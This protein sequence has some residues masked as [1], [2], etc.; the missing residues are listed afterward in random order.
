M[1]YSESS[2]VLFTDLYQLTM[3]QAYWQAR[4]TAQGTFSLFF[5]SYP[6]NRGYFVFAGL[7][8]AI[9]YLEDLRFSPAD[10]DSLRSLD[11]FD[12]GYLEFL[13]GVRFTGNIRAMSEGSIVFS[14][15]PVMEVS[16]PII[17]AQLAE[18]YLV[19]IVNLQTILATKAS[20][21]IHAARG[22]TVVDFAARRT[23]GGE[24][25]LKLA[26]TSYMVGFAGTSNVMASTMF[27]I[28]AYGTM[29]HSFI[30]TF[31]EETDAF[32]AYAK[33]FPDTSTFLVDTFDTIAGTEKAIKV[34][35]EMKQHGHNL[36]AIRLDSGN[37]TD[38][39]VKARTMLD[40]AGLA[41]V[42]VFASGGMDEFEIESLVNEGAPIGGFGVGTK[43][44][45]SADAPWADCVYKLVEYD[46]RPVMKLSTDKATLPGQKQ[47]YRRC[48]SRGEYAGDVIALAEEPSPGDTAAGLLTDVMRQGKA[49]Q[50]P[51]RLLELREKYQ[52]EFD[53]LPSGHKSLKSPNRYEVGISDKL[54]RLRSS[55]TQDLVDRWARGS[56]D[57]GCGE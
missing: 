49:I 56:T 18:T 30:E 8:D 4:K 35:L 50:Q 20:R 13:A 32:R 25:A 45:V 55:V 38:L 37:L 23:H 41:D 7:A 40:A 33:S 46:G 52:R 5:R 3:A 34:A 42:Q 14:D 43:L 19:N 44:G 12:A 2:P 31:S 29:A 26:R 28:P 9:R 15:E 22:R 48:N 54:E 53:C 27:G 47:V 36:R 57:V 51:P 21:I 24:A 39:S 6:Q 10:L 16:G 11:I 17:V 1:S